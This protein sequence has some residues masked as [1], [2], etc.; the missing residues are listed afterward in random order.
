MSREFLKITTPVAVVVF[1]LFSFG[2]QSQQHTKANSELWFDAIFFFLS[3]YQNDLDNRE[4]AYSLQDL[5]PVTPAPAVEES[6]PLNDFFFPGDSI[7]IN[8]STALLDSTD[9]LSTELDSIPAIIDSTLLDSTA[10]LE[11]FKHKR[12]DVPHTSIYRKKSSNLYAQPSSTNKKRVVQ[13][14]STGKFVEIRDKIGEQTVKVVLRIPIE[15]YIE[16]QMKA[17]ERE[18]W[19]E[20][21]YK[22]ELKDTAMKQLG[23]IIKDFT[24]FEIPLPSVGVL[25]IFGTPKISLKIGG[26]V[27]IH[28]AWRSET[29]EGVTA[30]LLGNTRNEP[31]FR[32]QVQ[33]NVDGMIGDKLQISADWNTERTFEYE[34]QLKIKYTGYEDEI[35]QSVE[36]GNVSLQT[37]PLI[38]GG[39]ALFGI[40]AKFKMGPLSLTTIASQKKGEVKE[41]SISGGS[42]STEFEL[43]AYD[44]SKNNYFVHKDY[45]DTN[46]NLFNKYYGNTQ[47]Q[48]ELSYF[49]K[50]I[51][52]WRSVKQSLKNPNERNAIAYID[53]EPRPINGYPADKR[54]ENTEPKPG[55][56]VLD[57]FILLTEG[58]DYIV[59]RYT[60]FI[61]LKTVDENE[62]IAV[63]FRQEGPTPSASD[64]IFF[65]DFINEAGADTSQRMILTLIKPKNLLPQWKKAWNLLLKNIYSIGG[66]DIKKDGFEFDIKYDVAGS[67]PQSVLGNV[68][69]LEAFGLDLLDA[70]GAVQPDGIFDYKP[71]LT[72]I[73]E[74][75]EIIFPVLQPF[76]RDL[77][78]QLATVSNYNYDSL[79]YS[80]V[81]DTTATVAKLNSEKDKWLLTG[82][83]S[84]SVASRISLGFNVVENSVRVSLNGRELTPGV[85]FVVDYN[86]GQLTIRNDAALVPGANLKISFEENDLFQFASKTIL[87]ARGEIDF[88]RKTKLGF[89]ALNLTQQTLSDKIRIGEEPLSNT[90]YGVDLNTSADLPF[91]TKALDNI[92]STREMS[93]L[94]FRGEVAYMNPDPNTK[95]STIES[96]GGESIAY[97]DDF[98]ATKTI[99]P[100]GISYTTWKDLSVPNRL[101][102]ITR[103]PSLPDSLTMH[104]K[105][106]SFWFNVLPS[107]V[108][109]RH[110]WPEKKVAQGD[111]QVTVLDYVF[112]PSTPGTYN[113]KPELDHPDL[114]WG[115]MM[116]LLSSASNNLE[117]QNIEFIEFWLQIQDALPEAKVYIDLGKISEDVIPNGKL[118]TE[119]KNFN[120][121][122]DEGEDLGIDGL[123]DPQEALLLEPG[124][125]RADPSGDN[126]AYTPRSSSEIDIFDYY[127]INGTEGNASLTDIGRIPDTEDLNRNGSVDLLNSY[128]RYEIP[129]LPDSLFNSYIA[130]GGSNDWYLYRIP[131]KEY[132]DMIGSPSFSDVEY[133][134][135]FVTGS[136]SIVHVRLAEFN[137]VGNQWRKRIK[138]DEVLSI[139][140]VNIEDNPY[141]YSSP[142][143]VSRERDRSRVDQDVLRN[144]QSLNLVLNGLKYGESREAIKVLP[145]SLDVFNYSEM[146]LFLHGDENTKG[147]DVYFRFGSDTNNY[148]EYRQKL[149]GDPTNDDWNEVRLIFSQLTA[150]KQKRDSAN[151][152]YADTVWLSNG[153]FY[154]YRV[155]GNPTLTSIKFLGIGLYNY[156]DP[157][158]QTP[159]SGEVW[160]NELRVIGA[161]DTPGWAYSLSTSFKL[162]DLVTINFN[163]SKTDPYFH[164]LADRFGSR[165]DSRNWGLSADLNV[166]KVLPVNLPGSNL[167]LNYS[168]TESIGK[169]LY[170]P[171]TD[172]K[173]DEAA[174]S[175]KTK[176]PEQVK[177]ESQTVSSSDTWTASGIKLLIPVNHWLIR[178]SF[179]SLTYSFNYNKSFSRS[180]TVESA[181]NWQW[182]AS[183]NYAVSLSPDYHFYPA[184]IPVLGSV[185]GLLS[186][187]RNAKFY[188]TPQTFTWSIQAKRSR[189][190]NITRE[191][192]NSASATTISRDF[193]AN[194]SLAIGWKFTEGG[195]LNLSTSY[196]V[197]VASSLTYL[198]TDLSNNQRREG[199]IW[200]D[201]ISSGFFGKDYSYQQ[202]LDFRTSPKLPTL[203]DIN[204]NFTIQMGYN[205]RYQWSNNLSQE[206]LGR[207]ANY[208]NRS[209]V[210]LTLRLKALM[211]PL[212]KED[213]A[214]AAQQPPPPP[215]DRGRE[216]SFSDDQPEKKE[217]SIEPE[218]KSGLD[219]LLAAEDSVKAIEDSLA[220][221]PKKPSALKNA[222][223]FLR[224]IAKTLLFDY[225]SITVSFS[226]DNSYSASGLQGNKTGFS[227]FWGL[228]TNVDNGP[229]RLFMLGLSND[230]GLRA[231]VETANLSDNYTQ[232]NQIDLKT[233]RPLWEG[234]KIDLTW[235]V[236]WS[237]NKTTQ[238]KPNAD[239]TTS[240]TSMSSTGTL[241]RSYLSFPPVFFLS[242]FKSG[243]KRVHELYDPQ[244]ENPGENLSQAFSKGFE[245]L[246]LLENLGFLKEF[247]K[248]IPR[249]N[250]RITWDGLEKFA[251]FKSFTKRVSLDHAYS[252][253]YTEG[254][255]LT[256]DGEQVTQSQKITYGFAPLLGLN[257]TLLP[258]WDGNFGGSVKYS[259][260]S[261]FDLGITTKNITETFSREIGVTINYSK[262][263]FDIPLFGVALKNDIEFSFSYSNTKN[264]TV[265]YNMADFNEE[266]TPQDGTVR[267]SLEPRIKYVIS[268]RV[269]LSIFYKRSTI[270]P[271][272]AARVSPTTTTEAGLDVKISIQ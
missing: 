130:G 111:E 116:K 100:I 113:Y 205:V 26:S 109:V 202:T 1:S 3:G 221:L 28:G 209:N 235:K 263:G 49:I 150:I 69:L 129:L 124:D 223:L 76:G 46:I 270:T 61:T 31:D 37:S 104:Y 161:D 84:G 108:N 10:R 9:S 178:D 52:V 143:G 231:A 83:Y 19:D 58:V 96:D 148:Y 21:V 170:L 131:L 137:L 165:V 253:N 127:N 15:E 78:K 191:T 105:G 72:I 251:L 73:P 200:R 122:I 203:W 201:I 50:E 5:N 237:I 59:N 147:L 156:K 262:T 42:Q 183:V 53:L 211:E 188:Y 175:S 39:E 66:R 214:E 2:F 255:R 27:D 233:S 142:P 87:G 82:K 186:D 232:K 213:P 80:A 192:Q 244:A 138:D 264:S 51:E 173:V 269:T 206:Q 259:A 241:D 57:R 67:D 177:L 271:E 56:I 125:T 126:F 136:D 157:V 48:M 89:T 153:D 216:R 160:V 210:S 163:L 123:T 65:G 68:R 196:N 212:F 99:N 171:G 172:I 128:Y 110:I 11:H 260:R 174:A 71:Q 16:L 228:K 266:G 217:M 18:M 22:Y 204:K 77:P 102:R 247:A 55:E 158:Y 261:G 218:K 115:G 13:I 86:I 63:A 139:S 198:E 176:T 252:S 167:R 121:L 166:L 14:D 88:S 118:D 240:I 54:N 94:T 95:K 24:D 101:S 154:V 169:P 250:W 258:L 25:S 249:A 254:W 179:N 267:T 38:G 180:P 34:N 60:G 20:L 245:S 106:K 195:F 133:I 215:R 243:I 40:K 117:D 29:T 33:V 152:E 85:D 225:E 190:T 44:Y 98:E 103:I 12:T 35:V 64:D 4:Q 219:S 224:T 43:K 257:L 92:I 227:N 132:K 91:V 93:T 146:K 242:M 6:I 134:R 97:I 265:I 74:T 32:Q 70:S 17:R 30:S 220:L 112:L 45:A 272:G 246:P 193:T 141:T 238:L 207:S 151:V 229:P 149:V 164:K 36:A 41:K 114:A 256:A 268:S 107:N 8:D 79:K 184:D 7:T 236:G 181:K 182:Q 199:E 144:E 208:S 23:D 62:N 239:G 187:Y 75:G 162:A 159:V 248:Y 155:K 47:P 194:R 226:N 197:D 90:I 230:P 145:R 189:S 120:D 234:A 168:H 135:F 81:Y 185:I 140:V 222:L 119:D